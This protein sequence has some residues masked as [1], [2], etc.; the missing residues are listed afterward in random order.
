MCNYSILQQS[1]H[2]RVLEFPDDSCLN[3]SIILVIAKMVILKISSFL[4][5]LLLGILH[6]NSESH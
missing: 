5:P 2:P 4:L 3:P 1:F 6:N